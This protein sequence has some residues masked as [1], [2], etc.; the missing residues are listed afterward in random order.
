V[1]AVPSPAHT[2]DACV[3]CL[4]MVRHACPPGCVRATCR[5]GSRDGASVVLLGSDHVRLA[6]CVAA[7]QDW[8]CL[9][10]PPSYLKRAWPL[11]TAAVLGGSVAVAGDR[12]VAICRSV[13]HAAVLRERWHFFG[14]SGAQHKPFRARFL[15]WVSEECLLVVGHDL[16]LVDDSSEARAVLAGC[17]NLSDEDAVP[18]SVLLLRK[19]LREVL[20]RIELDAPWGRLWGCA[21]LRSDEGH[22]AAG[23]F[24]GWYGM[25]KR[26]TLILGAGTGI[27][28]EA[29]PG[30][31]MAH[32]DV[33][34]GSY[35]A[36]LRRVR[37]ISGIARRLPRGMCPPTGLS[38]VYRDYGG[39][40]RGDSEPCGGG[41]TSR[42]EVVV[43]LLDGSVLLSSHH[44]AAVCILRRIAR[45]QPLLQILPPGSSQRLWHA[46]GTIW[47]L[48]TAGMWQWDVDACRQAIADREVV[49]WSHA[50]KDPGTNTTCPLS[51]IQI[52]P[53]P[54]EV[55]PL[56]ILMAPSAVLG[57]AVLPTPS[58]YSTAGPRLHVQPFVHTTI[59]KLFLL[60][61]PAAALQRARTAPFRRRYCLELL[62]HEALIEVVRADAR[63]CMTEAV[64]SDHGTSLRKRTP[65]DGALTAD[66]PATSNVYLFEHVAM[67]V[68]ELDQTD[69]CHIVA[70]C[71]RKTDALHWERLFAACGHPLELVRAFLEAGD[72]RCAA[73]LLLPVRHVFGRHA[74]MHAVRKVSQAA[75]AQGL[76]HLVAYLCHWCSTTCCCD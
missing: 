50:G 71:A 53:P 11:R 32:M 20:M 3:C 48:T 35:D 34:K 65:A 57:C 9:P 76:A 52:L 19:D 7:A 25:P 39:A 54:R 23:T 17:G 67:L 18:L 56:A 74:C 13:C 59:R 55:C 46:P 27:G 29:C 51:A 37:V 24:Q 42:L 62:L 72:V 21:A 2:A 28:M 30:I 14:A 8:R 12:G 22:P 5:G 75:E 16:Y 40:E 10:V 43:A 45:L 36:A 58:T 68:R 41:A 15:H 61:Q 33:D 73:S 69:W 38:A 49:V 47:T 66:G 63:P 44:V 60:A 31:G 26:T 70:G 6:R 64:M 1:L 4:A